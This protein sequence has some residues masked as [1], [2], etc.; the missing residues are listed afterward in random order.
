VASQEGFSFVKLLSYWDDKNEGEKG[1][2]Y[3]WER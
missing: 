2:K 3:E 1:L